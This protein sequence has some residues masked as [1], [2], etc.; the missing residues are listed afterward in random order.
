M[1]HIISSLKAFKLTVGDDLEDFETRLLGVDARVGVAPNGAEFEHCRSVW[2]GLCLMD[3]NVKEVT[4]LGEIVRDTTATALDAT[5]GRIA[6]ALELHQ[7]SSSAKTEKM[8]EDVQTALNEI[9]DFV[10]VLGLEQEKLSERFLSGHG[11]VHSQSVPDLDTVKAQIRLLEARIPSSSN[12]RLGGNLFQSR[13]DVLMFIEDYVP[14]NAFHLF[15]DVVTLL[16]SLTTSHVERKDVLQE[17]YQSTKVG[18]NEASARHM[19]S[20]R[21]ILPTVFGRT[22]EG[23]PVS[24]KHLLPAVKS[25]KDWNTYD[26]VSGTKGCMAAGMED[27]KY[28]FRQDINQSFQSD[29]Q[30]PART[31]ALEMHDLAQN[32]VMEMSSWMDSFYQELVTTSEASEDEAWDVVGACIKK[33]FE[34]I[35]VPRAQA[36]NATMDPCPKNQCA[37]Y[38]WALVQ[39]HKIMK[40]FIEAR[41]RNHAAIA[42]VIVLHIFKTQVTRVSL[43]ATIKR[44]EGRISALEKGKDT[45]GK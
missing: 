17:W 6:Q 37:T 34:V 14:S 43:T 4:K 24:A 10:R 19:A 35:R 36:A 25:F 2:D 27:L 40:E 13:V 8:F 11:Q 28:Q 38:L 16:E 29:G 1:N 30:M 42:P 41:F 5:N 20:F 7:K 33:M 39:S 3:N 32:F 45:K 22:K 15:H 18:V 31:L 44:L 21:L 9:V 12:G 26:G 23:A